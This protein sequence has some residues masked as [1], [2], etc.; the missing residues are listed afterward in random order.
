MWNS[1][2]TNGNGNGYGANREPTPECL[3]TYIAS[4][5]FVFNP[6]KEQS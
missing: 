3:L 6:R 5:Q 2:T 1:L 4:M